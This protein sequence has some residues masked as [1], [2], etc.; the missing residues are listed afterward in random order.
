MF[1]ALSNIIAS[2]QFSIYSDVN[3]T[4][5]KTKFIAL[6]FAGF[7]WF[8]TTLSAQTETNAL[9]PAYAKLLN[10]LKYQQGEIDLRAVWQN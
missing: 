7:A 5:M 9:P 4:F 2:Q 10:S 6:L 8:T 1:R 3:S